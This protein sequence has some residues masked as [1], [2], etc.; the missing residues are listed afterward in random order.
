MTGV[1]RPLAALKRPR[2]V[3]LTIAFL[4]LAYPAALFLLRKRPV[5]PTLPDGR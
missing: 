2:G 5:N 4:N 3:T 1:R